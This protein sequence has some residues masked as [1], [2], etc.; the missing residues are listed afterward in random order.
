MYL[1]CILTGV[2]PSSSNKYIHVLTLILTATYNGRQGLTD[3]FMNNHESSFLFIYWC[4]K[5]SSTT[6]VKVN[7]MAV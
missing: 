2:Y 4:S 3:N 6:L 1:N 5:T 7:H